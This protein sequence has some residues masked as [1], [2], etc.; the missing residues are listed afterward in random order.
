MSNKNK[1]KIV[2]VL[3]AD[4]CRLI[5]G[6]LSALACSGQVDILRKAGVSTANIRSLKRL[7]HEDTWKLAQKSENA[8]DVNVLLK[9]LFKKEAPEEYMPYLLYG[10]NN[11]QMEHHFRINAAK[12]SKWRENLAVEKPFRARSLPNKQYQ[13]VMEALKVLCREHTPMGIPAEALLTIAQQY[14]VS[15]GAIWSE[16]EKWD[17]KK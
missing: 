12:C 14:Q 4:V 11:K 2:D 8:I 5:V 9:G 17:L 13:E 3:E 7:S 15:L 10:V 1:I 16:L 6:H